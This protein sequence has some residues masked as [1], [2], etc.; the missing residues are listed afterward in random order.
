MSTSRKQE[1]PPG[2]DTF[3]SLKIPIQLQE[4]QVQYPPLEWP[5]RI[6]VP[7]KELAAPRAVPAGEMFKFS[8]ILPSAAPVTPMA[9]PWLKLCQQLCG[10]AAP[11]FVL[12]AELRAG[13]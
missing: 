13:S 2:S 12:W 9:V 4:E 3:Q 7:G 10:S 6:P 5:Q 8:S 11:G 1:N